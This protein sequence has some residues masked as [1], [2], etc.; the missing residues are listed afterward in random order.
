MPFP[1]NTLP[2]LSGGAGFTL[3]DLSSSN[4]T[5]LNGV[6][7][8][9]PTVLKN[10]DKIAFG[11]EAFTFRVRKTL[12][13]PEETPQVFPNWLRWSLPFYC[14]L[15]RYWRSNKGGCITV[16]TVV[17]LLLVIALTHLGNGWGF[18]DGRDE[19]RNGASGMSGGSMLKGNN[20]YAEARAAQ[21]AQAAV[22]EFTVKASKPEVIT[23]VITADTESIPHFEAPKITEAPK[24]PEPKPTEA[25]IP[26]ITPQ[27]AQVDQKGTLILP[28]TPVVAPSFQKFLKIV[29]AYERNHGRL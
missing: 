24:V 9:E 22:P 23:P 26:A 25:P 8:T 5:R 10:R 21:Q 19:G 15:A 20:L 18:G 6:K 14:T 27:Q 7:I 11:N 12:P 1:P 17:R 4:G 3:E 29:A 2:S 28:N 13:S 16:A